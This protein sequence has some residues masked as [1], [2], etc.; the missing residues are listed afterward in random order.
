MDIFTFQDLTGEFSVLD[1][2]LVLALS[3]VLSA[4]IGWVYKLTHRGTSYTQS[5][6]FTLVLNGMVVALVMMVVGSNIARAFS[7]VGALSIIR[8]RNAVKE[9]RDVGFIFFTMAIGMAIGTRFYLLAIVAAVVISLVVVIMMRFNWFAR[10]AAGQILRTQ[11]PSGAAFD[12]LFDALFLKYT[13]SSELIS[14]D[15]VDNGA[16]TELTYSVGLKKANRVEE[17]VSELRSLNDDNKISLI[18]GYNT[19]DL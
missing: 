2:T 5:F 1:V 13:H 3:F 4:F 6:V 17:F 10:E 14:V 18:A 12:K 15:T 11:V 16:L 19:T 9:T 8:F 7:L